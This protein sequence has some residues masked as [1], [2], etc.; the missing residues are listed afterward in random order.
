MFPNQNKTKTK[1]KNAGPD[2]FTEKLY[3]TFKEN[4]TSI[5]IKLFYKIETGGT[6]PNSFYEAT[7][8]LIPKIPRKI[9]SDQ[10]S[11]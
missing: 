9:A 2:V 5:C 3:P 7:D 6:L 11:L 10:L 4:L 8:M 1:N